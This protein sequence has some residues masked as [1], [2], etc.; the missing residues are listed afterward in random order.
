MSLKRERSS[1][2]SEDE[3]NFGYHIEE[4][5]YPIEKQRLDM[6]K[7]M[8]SKEFADAIRSLMDEMSS[9]S[10]VALPYTVTK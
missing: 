3:D 8:K 10:K 6:K 5:D 1:E 4:N 7:M 9:Q 2:D